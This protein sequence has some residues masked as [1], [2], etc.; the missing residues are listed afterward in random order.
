MIVSKR[1]RRDLDPAYEAEVDTV[2]KETW[3]R[4]LGQFEDSNIYQT[5]SYGQVRSGEPNISHLVLRQHSRV[6]AIAQC[7]IQKAPI[8]GAGIA[9]LMWGPLWRCRGTAPELP[10]FRQAIRA[11]RNEY[12]GKRGLLLRIAPAAFED[13]SSC[14]LSIL[15]EE[16]FTRGTEKSG[17]RTIVMD[18]GPSLDEIRKGLRPHWQRELKVAERQNVEVLEGGSDELFDMFIGIYKEMVARKKFAEP[19]DIH[20]FR[21]IQRRL[22]VDCKMKILL[23]R[24]SEGLC[25]GL[26]ADTVGGTARYLFGATSTKGMKSRGSYLLQWKL[27]EWLKEK[28]VLRYDLNGIN[29]ESNPGTY[30]FKSDLAG[31]KG[32][33]VRL[34]G[35]FESCGSMV[36]F[37][38]V[39]MGERMRRIGRLL[40]RA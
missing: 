18:L 35:R 2:Q 17:S 21:E 8:I 9:Y 36:S 6:V 15:K 25:A 19:N 12:A 26:I 31:E 37:A 30:K 1:A 14:L 16:G 39:N 23:C 38:C 7:R 27:I 20:E 22:P 40:A 4:L 34:L 29:P 13:E 33:D 5:W 32:R 11:L 10:V 3:Y 28:M 24:S